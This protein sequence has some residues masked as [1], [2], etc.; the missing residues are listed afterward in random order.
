[1]VWSGRL[2]HQ[3]AKADVVELKIPV[4]IQFGV[5]GAQPAEGLNGVV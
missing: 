4:C 5:E 2:L 1:M 3:V